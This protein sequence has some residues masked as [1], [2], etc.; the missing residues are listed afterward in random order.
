MD[1]LQECAVELHK[2]TDTDADLTLERGRLFISNHKNNTPL[3]VRLRFEDN[4]YFAGPGQGWFHWGVTWH[5]H[6]SY[7]GLEE[8]RRELLIDVGSKA[9]E[10]PFSDPLARD[11]RLSRAAL[12]D[13]SPSYPQG[14]V[15]GIML[16]AKE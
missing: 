10:P 11:F 6:K 2:P 1:Y 14:P 16:G 15:P 13:L 5:R 8:F 7:N 3:V 9:L 4:V 12:N